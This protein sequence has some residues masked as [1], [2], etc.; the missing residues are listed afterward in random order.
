MLGV[1][2]SRADS[3]S[4]HIGEQLREVADWTAE[5]DGSRPDAAGGGTIYR[6]PGV[7]IREFEALH[8]DLEAPA[9]A[10]DEPSVLAF[11]SRH[12]GETGPLLTAHHTGN[13]GPAEHGGADH[14]LARAAPN[15][16]GA[17]LAALARHAPP[18]YE[19]GM[20]ATHHGPTDV[21]APSLFVEIGSEAANWED[22]AAAEAVARAILDLVDE[23]ADRPPEGGEA[24]GGGVRRHLVGLG[25]G[26]YAPRFER[27]GRETDWA[28]G[29][30]APDWGLDALGDPDTTTGRAV[31]D[32]LFS[33]SRAT[34]GLLADE[35]PGLEAVV[36]DLGYRTV[37]ETWV[38]ETDGVPLGTVAE[39]EAAVCPIEEGLR[40]GDPARAYGGA[41]AVV[42][43]PA[44]LLEE[45]R[46]IDA[47]ASRTAV[48]S[49][50]L[51]F[52]T[53]QEGSRVTGPVALP[54]GADP[55]DLVEALAGVLRAGYDAVEVTP[56]AVLAREEAFDPAL[57]REAGVPEGPA[58]GR[59]AAG[60]AVT[61]DGEQVTPADVHRKRVRRFPRD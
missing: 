6:R 35:R 21:G 32:A 12:A 4:V 15:A 1:V 19:V 2:V 41:V 36:A 5:T 51:A 18:G 31:I 33:R 42:D 50:A 20:E 61:V 44:A 38:R 24:A 10:F 59:L 46:G 55:A 7:A 28:I 27:L 23:P 25:G 58:F 54:A 8:L 16:H 34:V 39:L 26:H 60:E 52:G 56:E 11:A 40:L 3:A 53:D 37:G 49:L 30:V 43:P 57:A 47:G 22:E 17:V 45:A 14:A 48:A 13:L 9:A 29:H